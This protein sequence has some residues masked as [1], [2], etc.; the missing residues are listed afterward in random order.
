MERL[1]RICGGGMELFINL[2]MIIVFLP[3]F[4]G[5]MISVVLIWG[6]N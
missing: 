2:L 5:L 6:E 4:I 3:F 1:K